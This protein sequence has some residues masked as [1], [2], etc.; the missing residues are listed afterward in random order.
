MA[1]D[2]SKV[3]LPLRKSLAALVMLAGLGG[4]AY[5]ADDAARQEA[6]RNAYAQAVAA[7]AG[8]SAAVKIAMVMGHY[9]ESSN[10]HI[11]TPYIDK[12]GK[13]RPLTVCNG[14]TGPGVVAGRYYTPA[15]CYALERA[16]YLRAETA[17]K[18]MLTRWSRYDPFTQA[19]FIDFAWNKG[20]TNFS[21]STMRR[22]ANAGDLLGACRENPRWNRG[23]VGGVSTV[24]PG[25]VIR[26]ESNDEICREWRLGGQ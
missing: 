13:G 16:R 15:D 14:V 23:T 8:T 24:L 20:E 10:R 25:L 3:P 2:L 12:V 1:S 7:D 18:Q 17:A 11:G 22:K 6:Q 21:T 19:T 26:G 4:A 5:L 9:Y